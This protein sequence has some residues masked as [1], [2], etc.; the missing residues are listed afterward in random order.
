MDPYTI[1]RTAAVV[2]LVAAL[3]VPTRWLG[4]ATSSEAQLLL[5]TLI[6]AYLVARDAFAG[7]LLGFALLAVY[8]RV[9]TD[10]LRTWGMFGSSSSN[11][12]PMAPL[13]VGDYITPEHL[14]SAQD[15]VYDPAAYSTEL[16]GIQGMYGK[17][18][19][20]A[21][22]LTSD[23]ETVAGFDGTTVAALAAA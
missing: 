12:Y 13:V 4:A 7:L 16:K 9:H 20:G 1:D 8:F 5:G 2:V 19:Y 6:V 17:G 14:A 10:R 21:Q 18:V 15:N 23:D 22:A 11:T 3:T